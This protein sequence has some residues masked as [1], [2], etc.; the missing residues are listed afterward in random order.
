MAETGIPRLLIRDAEM[1]VLPGKLAR[2]RR[3]GRRDVGFFVVGEVEAAK[4]AVRGPWLRFRCNPLQFDTFVMADSLKPVHR[5]QLVMLDEEGAW[6]VPYPEDRKKLGEGAPTV[7]RNPSGRGDPGLRAEL[8]WWNGDPRRPV[9]PGAPGTSLS[10]AEALAGKRRVRANPKGVQL[11]ATDLEAD[12][13]AAELYAPVAQEIARQMAAKWGAMDFHRDPAG[14][15]RRLG[16]FVRDLIALRFIVYVVDGMDDEYAPGGR[17]S[18]KKD[19]AHFE[20]EARTFE[21]YCEGRAKRVE[22]NLAAS[23]ADPAGRTVLA[24]RVFQKAPPSHKAGVAQAIDAAYPEL[25]AAGRGGDISRI[26]RAYMKIWKEL[27]GYSQRLEDRD[28]E[29]AG[30]LTTAMHVEL[31]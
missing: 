3:E 1:L 30:R 12:L 17:R 6:L 21:R 27:L 13:G 24:M 31:P 29:L 16:G 23:R 19:R 28:A 20:A 7:R 9:A 2:I 18:F 25:Y 22:R 14:A 15:Y 26:E 5:A 10:R 4:K 8:D 11:Y